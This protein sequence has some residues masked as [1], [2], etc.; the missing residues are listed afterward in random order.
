MLRQKPRFCL[1]HD[2]SGQEAWDVLKLGTTLPFAVCTVLL[3]EMYKTSVLD[4]FG[5]CIVTEN[6]VLVEMD[7]EWTPKDFLRV[8]NEQK[9][10]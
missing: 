9:L 10:F 3:N 4:D 1:G 2:A 7:W 8:N 6:M 5:I